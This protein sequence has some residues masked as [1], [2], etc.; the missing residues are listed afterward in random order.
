M[1]KYK[2]F[3]LHFCFY[4]INFA[5]ICNLN[6]VTAMLIGISQLASP[7]LLIASFALIIGIPSKA[8]YFKSF[9]S[10]IFFSFFIT[11]YFIGFIVR[12]LSFNTIYMVPII[13]P[14]NNLI[15]SGFIIFALYKYLSFFLIEKNEH[16]LVFKGIYYALLISTMAIILQSSSEIIITKD[17]E[18]SRAVGFFANPNGAGLIANFCMAFLIYDINKYK[19]W[20]IFK[21]IFLIP[22]V[23]YASFLTLSKSSLTISFILILFNFIYYFTRIKFKIFSSFRQIIGITPLVFIILVYINFKFIIENFFP[24]KTRILYL[25]ELVEAG[26]LT[27]EN[28]SGRTNVFEHGIEKILESPI[29]GN[30]IMYFSYLPK[31]GYGV[32]NTYLSVWGDSGIIPFLCMISLMLIILF[33]AFFVEIDIGYLSLALVFVYILAFIGSHNGLDEKIF[34]LFMTYN[35]CYLIYGKKI[36]NI[37]KS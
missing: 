11:Y 35:I 7:L 33:R 18:E 4:F 29:Y 37:S 6:G 12:M 28:T 9:E 2:N 32:H 20:Y 8:Q 34:N 27:E 26:E 24:E 22:I 19:K 15:S 17:Q 14:I 5:I 23:F 1:K 16:E 13:G 21:I 30:G 36:M 10:K 25:I 31:E 3:I